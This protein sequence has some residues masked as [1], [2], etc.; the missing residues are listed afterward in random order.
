[1]LHALLAAATLA[2][3]VSE[4]RLGVHFLDDR[5]TIGARR[6]VAAGPRVL[7]LF[8]LGPGMR[9]ALRDYKTRWPDGTVVVRIWFQRRWNLQDDPEAAGRAFWNEILK[10]Q[11]D[12]LTDRERSWIDY[13]EGPNEGDSTPTWGSVE[14][15]RWF[16]RFTVAMVEAM[17]RDG[18][19]PLIGNIAVGNP[20]GTPEEVAAKVEAF[21]P[22]FEAAARARGAWGYHAYTLE[23][24]T[25]PEKESWTSLRYRRILDAVRRKRPDLARLPLIL[26][27][28][29]VDR[30]GNSHEDGWVSRGSA[31]QFERWLRWFDSELRKDPT[32]VGATLFASGG[33]ESWPSFELEAFL[34]RL[35]RMVGEGHR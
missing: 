18:A 35:A 2:P 26:T 8:D 32:V 14:D 10:P 24:S 28:A 4:C 27:E 16:A 3:S 34:P 29:G 31:D 33:F 20:G 11:H 6:L 15:A 1:M 23:Y 7:K 17:R 9:E 5:Y 19:R 12:R 25:D 30:A 22:A 13:W 21:L